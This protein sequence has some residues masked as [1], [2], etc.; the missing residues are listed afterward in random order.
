MR[1][2]GAGAEP[3]PVDVLDLDGGVERLGGGVVQGAADPAH[4][5]QDTETLAGL[6]VVGGGVL[7]RF[8]ESSQHRLVAV[9]LGVLPGLL[10]AF[11]NPVT[12][13]AG[14]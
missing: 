2:S 1:A 5:L 8:K 4:R 7:L 6:G 13:G 10:L 11:A 9:I 3:L 12:Y 14:C